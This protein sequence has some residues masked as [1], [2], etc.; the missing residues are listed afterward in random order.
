M[1]AIHDDAHQRAVKR[2]ITRRKEVGV[3]QADIALNLG[4]PQSFVSKY[5]RFERCLDAVECALIATC[6]TCRSATTL[7]L[8]GSIRTANEAEG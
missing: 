2:L 5:E 7:M 1:R 3:T 4:R 8:S 6:S